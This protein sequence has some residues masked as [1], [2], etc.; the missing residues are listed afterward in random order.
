MKRRTKLARVY[1]ADHCSDC[2]ETMYCT[3]DRRRRTLE[4]TLYEEWLVFRDR[5]C[6]VAVRGEAAA[7][8]WVAEGVY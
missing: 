1:T 4:T 6:V 7:V 5:T 3:A 8:R 2:N